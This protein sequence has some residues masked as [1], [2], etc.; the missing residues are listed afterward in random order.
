M[1]SEGLSIGQMCQAIQAVQVSPSLLITEDSNDAR[2]F[3]H[4][5]VSSGFAP[6]LVLES[7]PDGN[8]YHAVTAAGMKIRKK[9]SASILSNRIDD[10]AGDLVSLYVHDDRYSPYF[11]ADL[12][13]IKSTGELILRLNLLDEEGNIEDSE[14]WRLRHILIP[15]HG[16]IRLSFASLREITIDLIKMI[17]SFGE[18]YSKKITRTDLGVIKFRTLILRAPLYVQHLFYGSQQLAEPQ[19]DTFNKKVLLSRYV[20]VARLSSNAFGTLDILFDTTSTLK[21]PHC[22]GIVA[23]IKNQIFPLVLAEFL[24]EEL[25]C[26]LITD[27]H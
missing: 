8:S 22:L 19:R 11:R 9:H 5:A 24:S 15:I 7:Y 3:L 6:V 10:E 17:K 27:I 14:R 13:T 25:K 26:P 1:P 18:L 16:K 2:G 12:E 23:R 4:S 21:N 20:G